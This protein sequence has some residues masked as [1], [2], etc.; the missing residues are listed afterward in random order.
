[1]RSKYFEGGTDADHLAMP[2]QWKLW[3]QVKDLRSNSRR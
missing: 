2:A 1:M 3:I